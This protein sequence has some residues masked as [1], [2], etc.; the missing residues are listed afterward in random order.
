MGQ[1]PRQIGICPNEWA[2]VRPVVG[3][4]TAKFTIRFYI[5]NK[6]DNPQQLISIG[7]FH[8]I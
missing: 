2:A 4:G 1:I 8:K 7:T 3:G 5:D 6:L